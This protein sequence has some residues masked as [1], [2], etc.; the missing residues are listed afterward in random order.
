MINRKIA[1]KEKAE[2][3]NTKEDFE[4]LIKKLDKDLNSKLEEIVIL[5]ELE[6]DTYR[7]TFILEDESILNKLR[8]QLKENEIVIKSE[9]IM[10]VSN[11]IKNKDSLFNGLNQDAD[12]MVENLSIKSAS[13]L[14]AIDLKYSY[15]KL[16]V[17][18]KKY[19]KCKKNIN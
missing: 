1:Y 8:Q 13:Y 12:K 3:C 2:R 7:F 4:N 17:N 16:F 15:M 5:L 18:H 10:T 19:L 6:K 11:L 9:D 14:I